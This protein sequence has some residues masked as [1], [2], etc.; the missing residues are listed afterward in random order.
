M[1]NLIF[2]PVIPWWSMGLILIVGL[3][4]MWVGPSFATLS[5]N[6]RL[7]LALLRLGTL[8]LAMF[9]VARPGCVDQVVKRQN[10]LLVF[11]VD[12]SRS[13]EFPHVLDDSSRWQAVKETMRENESRIRKLAENQIETR[14]IGFDSQLT[15]LEIDE[16]TIQ[17]PAVPLGAETDIGSALY[18]TLLD[19]REERVIGMFV[20]SDGNQNA[21]DPDIDPLQAAQMLNDL[22]IPLY[23]VPFGLPGDAG[24]LADVAITNFGEQHVVNV[25]NEMTA[26]ATLVSRGYVNQDIR[27]DLIVTDSQGNDSVVATEF[28]RPTES[29]YEKSIE[30]KFRPTIPGEF[31]IKVRANPMPG[32]LAIRNN[33]LEGFLTVNDKGMRVLMIVGDLNWEQNRLRESLSVNEFMQI[34]FIEISPASR[35]TW[36]ITRYE[37]LFSDPSYDLFIL[38]DLDSR[39]L[40]NPG[41]YTKSLDGLAEAVYQGKGLLM[42]GGYHSF[43]AGLYHQ[44]PLADILPIKMSRTER[45]EFGSDVRRD[46]HVNEP[47]KLR[48]RD[49]FTTRLGDRE[50]SASMWQQIPPLLGANRIEPKDNALVLIESDDEIRRPIM[51][52]TEVGGR[53]AAFAGDSTWRWKMR[54]FGNQYD[55]FWRQVIL[56]LAKWDSRLDES[57]SIILPQRRFQPRTNVRFDVVVSSISEELEGDFRFETR[58]F[59]PQGDP[60]TIAL[61]QSGDQY[62]GYLDPQVVTEPGL[63]RL[64]VE[65]FRGPV[66]IGSTER[67]FI[68]MDRDKE[69]SNPVANPEYLVRLAS[70]TAEHG[71]QAIVPEKLAELLDQII[72]DPPVAQ[73][74]IPIRNRFGDQLTDS[75]IFLVVFVLLLSVEWF[76]RKKWGL[77]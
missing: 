19:V 2:Q 43:G 37:E 63:Y 55:Q 66:S 29:Y 16:Q 1:E 4:L 74:K 15:T 77:V 69:K 21:S 9:A 32:E 24:Q 25:K 28:V 8:L 59:A 51:V 53:V 61:S 35:G 48:P 75:S 44:T 5:K 10:A 71:G 76:L 7:T 40:H 41:L 36:P 11:L 27:V 45:Q 72:A 17:L 60:Q 57:I 6:Q 20:L 39:S 64:Q 34:D 58:L 54:G 42:L 18:R 56:W 12:T 22:E 68:V 31:R 62:F 30:L 70:Q 50:S 65:G 14:L 26:R 52:V 23:A 49:H 73:V 3:A 13:M 33:E 38:V 46:L 47:I 67:E